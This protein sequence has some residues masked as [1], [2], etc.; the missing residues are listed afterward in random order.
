MAS[1]SMTLDFLTLGA[2]TFEAPD[3]RRF[4]CL[5]LAYAALRRG[6]A[7]SIGVNAA[8]E[9]AVE[10]FLAGRLPFTRI[11]AV[12]EETL[13]QMP[14]TQPRTVDDV[15]ALDAMARRVAVTRVAA[16]GAPRSAAPIEQG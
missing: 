1:G 13:D 10:A 7:A 2:L 9:V 11:A 15:L 6:P 4:P 14:A 12:I 16:Q 5:T 3:L 8:N